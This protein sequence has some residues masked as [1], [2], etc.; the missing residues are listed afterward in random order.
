[1]A[2]GAAAAANIASNVVLIPRFG[3]LGP[4]WSNVISYAVL[5]GVAFVLSQR[6]YPIRYEYGRI[7][8]VVVAGVGAYLAAVLLVP[9]LRL[10]A[11][12][13][14]ARGLVVVAVFPTLLGVTGFFQRQELARIGGMVR[15]FRAARSQKPEVAPAAAEPQLSVDEALAE[16]DQ[17]PAVFEQDR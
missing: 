7:A 16:A 15:Q 12:G 2:A 10:A 4:A 6:L 17:D 1:V 3:I 14:L 11:A 5:A 9:D 13:V 8:R